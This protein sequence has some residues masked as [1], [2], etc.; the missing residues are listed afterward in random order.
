[1]ICLLH[2]L[3]AKVRSLFHNYEKRSK[4]PKNLATNNVVFMLINRL[5]TRRSVTTL[6]KRVCS[7]RNLLA[8]Q[9]VTSKETYLQ[10]QL[11]SC[12][13]VCALK[14]KLRFI[15]GMVLRKISRKRVGKI[16]GN[17]TWRTL[18]L[19][20]ATLFPPYVGFRLVG[21]SIL[22]PAQCVS[23]PRFLVLM[24]LTDLLP[25]D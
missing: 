19:I 13:P 17:L 1:M 23:Y 5:P 25:V 4:K 7:D 16:T 12:V 20:I 9:G 24:R 15:Q 6:R 10:H 22:P 2:P 14:L 11:R 8:K 3:Y 21:L 18:T